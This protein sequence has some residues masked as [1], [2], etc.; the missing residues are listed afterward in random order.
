M[1]LFCTREAPFA[2]LAHETRPLASIS[3][4][5]AL[6]RSDVVRSL[7]SGV[8]FSPEDSSRTESRTKS[9][10]RSVFLAE[11]ALSTAG[12]RRCGGITRH[13]IATA[14]SQCV[15]SCTA[16]TRNYVKTCTACTRNYVKTCTACTRNYIKTCTSW[17]NSSIIVTNAP[18]DGETHATGFHLHGEKDR[19]RYS[20]LV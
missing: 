8:H 4:R 1:R 19:G 18:G 15:I 9:P 5:R 3:R 11:G 2:A 6:Y 7:P 16:C 10:L 14:S 12:N 17:A 13:S 20:R